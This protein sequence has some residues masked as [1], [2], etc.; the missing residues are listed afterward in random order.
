MT[1]KVDLTRKLGLPL[2]TF[3]GL[4]TILGAGIYVLVGQVAAIAGFYAPLAFI[5][6]AII[7]SF[8]ALSYARLV[9]I[10]PKCAGEA[11]YVW[12][13]FNNKSL[14]VL[15]GWLIIITGT[16]SSAT[17]AKGFVGY[18]GVFIQIPA[19]LAITLLTCSLGILAIWG[20]VQ[21]MW[22]SAVMTI[23]EIGGLL[24]VIFIAGD[25][26][27][28]PPLPINA[29]FVPDSFSSV[30]GVIAGAFLA[31][32]AFIGFE[33][34]VNVVEETKNSRFNLPAAIFL[35]IFI[36]STLYILIA[37]IA[38]STLSIQQLTATEA[39]LTLILEGSGHLSRN[40]ITLISIFAIVNG[41]LIQIIKCS[42]VLY[43]MAREN[44]APTIFSNVSI[45][46][47]TPVQATL[48]ISTIVLT[49]A[50]CLPL[51]TLAKL[52]SFVVLIVFLM[53]NVSLWRIK[54]TKKS[55][56]EAGMKTINFPKVGASLCLFLL[57]FQIYELLS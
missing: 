41:A 10:Y 30:F 11:I 2:V 35:S 20:I 50:L 1:E 47:K 53:V 15:I 25:V 14:S 23:I 42:R 44:M 51:I 4:G 13:A 40:V 18:L 7:S 49:F 36:S 52:T 37:M 5:T 46:T 34:M 3:Y 24:L 39:P 17:I 31:F 21:S 26:L 16:V 55:D 12:K 27:F 8:T 56:Y 22:I 43:G 32:F 57:L 28:E 29:Y 54:I 33:D 9:S 6:A 19:W 48:V 38:V 45:K